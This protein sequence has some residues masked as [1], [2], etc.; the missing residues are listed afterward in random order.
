MTHS[1]IRSPRGSRIAYHHHAGHRPGVMFC[2]GFRSDMEGGKALALEAWCR[3]Q[4]R[5]FTRF[6]YSGHGASSGL[7]EDGTLGSWRDDAVAVLDQVAEGPQIIVGS[8]MG[9]WIMLLMALARPGRVAALLGIAAAPDFTRSLHRERLSAAQ[10][11]Q[12]ATDGWCELE[13]D[14]D[15]GRPYRIRRQLLDEAEQHLL[16]D[17]P[18]P[19]RQP[20]RLIHG[21]R[22]AD[23]PWETSLRL[24][25]R[26]ESDDVELQLVKN[27]SHR[28]SGAADLERM[29]DALARLLDRLER[30]ADRP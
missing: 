14:Y 20:V 5:Q 2:T 4:G 16:L 11:A 1:Y 19:L 22:D 7:F 29:I 9:G 21:E 17:A 8:S 24:L 30:A 27:G 15:D 26:L 18:L 6:D 13:S 3:R 28:L 25:Q 10:R 12:L 23:V